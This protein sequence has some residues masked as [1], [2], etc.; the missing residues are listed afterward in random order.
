[1]SV[2]SLLCPR[3]SVHRGPQTV[4]LSLGSVAN[5]YVRDDHRRDLQVTYDYDPPKSHSAKQP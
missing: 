4:R 5:F 1:M 2:Q 3:T